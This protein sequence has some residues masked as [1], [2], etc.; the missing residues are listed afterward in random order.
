MVFLELFAG[1]GGLTAEVRHRGRDAVAAE[2]HA[3]V[4]FDMRLQK[5]FR[6]ALKIVRRGKVRWLHGAPRARPIAAPAEPTPLRGC[7]R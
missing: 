7:R 1:E 3:V 2:L 6:K 4:P 5:D